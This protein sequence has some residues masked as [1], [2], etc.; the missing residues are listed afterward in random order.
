MEN[1]HLKND[2]IKIFVLTAVFVAILVSLIYWD[3]KSQLL[4]QLIDKVL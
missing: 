2:L 3:N 1:K 4:E